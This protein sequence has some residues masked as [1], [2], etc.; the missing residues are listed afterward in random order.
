MGAPRNVG[1]PRYDITT[2]LTITAA[3]HAATICDPVHCSPMYGG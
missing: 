3:I 2:H 1:S